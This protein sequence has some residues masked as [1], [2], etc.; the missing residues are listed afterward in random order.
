MITQTIDS[1][2]ELND[3][4]RFDALRVTA[5]D[6]NGQSFDGSPL[7]FTVEGQEQPDWLYEAANTK[8]V[9]VASR[10]NT[11]YAWFGVPDEYGNVTWAGPGDYIVQV[12]GKIYVVPGAVYDLLFKPP[13]TSDQGTPSA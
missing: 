10:G 8:K 4:I 6:Y 3:A 13:T 7:A 11:D 1:D 5:A 9:L 12:K 2:R